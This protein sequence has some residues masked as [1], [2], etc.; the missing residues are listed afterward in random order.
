M[1][2]SSSYVALSAIGMCLVI[3]SGQIDISVGSGLAVCAATSA[4]LA[5]NGWPFPAVP[6]MAMLVGGLIGL[7]N[8]TLSAYG[9][10]SPILVTLATMSILRGVLLFIAGGRWISLPEDFPHLGTKSATGIPFPPLIAILLVFFFS[11]F[12]SHTASGR[13]IYAVGGNQEAAARAGIS[14]QRVQVLAFVLSGVL[15]GLSGFLYILP[16]SSVQ[17]NA[18]IGFE[19]LVI[20]GV[21]VGGVNIF[22][23]SGTIP[24]AILGVLLLTVISSAINYLPISPFW[25]R[26]VQG[27]L[28]LAAVATNTLTRDREQDR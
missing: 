5:G 16:F 1:A 25:E 4:Q 26:A 24:G 12:M 13:Y 14:V 27:S 11:W 19:L 10:I 17:T 23:G 8:G 6:V 9:K 22:G 7:I 2:V 20:T 28:V 18:G 21:L 15:L 3:I